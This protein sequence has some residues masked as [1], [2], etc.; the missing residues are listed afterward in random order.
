MYLHECGAP[1]DPYPGFGACEGFVS[2]AKG[3]PPSLQPYRDANAGRLKITGRGH[4][5]ITQFLGPELLTK[6]DKREVRKVLGLWDELGLL[7]VVRDPRH[8]RALTRVFGSYKDDRW[9]RMIGDRRGPNSME[10][11][12]AGP[13][14]ELPWIVPHLPRAERSVS[15]QGQTD[16]SEYYHQIRVTPAR[17]A[18]NAV[19][20][21]MRMSQLAGAACLRQSP[22]AAVLQHA[23]LLTCSAS[24]GTLCNCPL[25][26]PCRHRP[27][28]IG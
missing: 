23:M 27:L 15:C 17:A 22:S 12:L 28:L 8:P 26:D 4:W 6:K 25:A 11:R 24:P 7:R 10:C 21:L 13:S 3:E 1:S 18:T 5:H 20:P 14:K 2:H 16:R 19:G 9:D